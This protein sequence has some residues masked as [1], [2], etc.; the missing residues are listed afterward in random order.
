MINQ[1]MGVKEYFCYRYAGTDP[2]QRAI[3]VRAGNQ[4]SRGGIL[5][6]NQLCE[7]PVDQ[8]RQVRNI[9]EKSLRV[10]LEEREKYMRESDKEI[11]D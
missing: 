3:W 4:L 6:M 9:G 10:I 5:T 8:I 1:N 11:N 2:K 7:M